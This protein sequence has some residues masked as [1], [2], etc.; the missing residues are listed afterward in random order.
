MQGATVTNGRKTK[1]AQKVMG[2]VVL[3]IVGYTVFGVPAAVL[4]ILTLCA[5]KISP[6]TSV[7]LCNAL[8]C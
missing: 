8:K 2:D 6:K 4:V 5:A 1:R 7:I 3:N